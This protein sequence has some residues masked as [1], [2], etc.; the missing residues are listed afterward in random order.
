MTTLLTSA[1]ISDVV[2]IDNTDIEFVFNGRLYQLEINEL[3]YNDLS[4]FVKRNIGETHY[5]F[6]T[7]QFSE[8]TAKDI[9][10][11]LF[12]YA[13]DVTEY[14][15][16]GQQLLRKQARRN[17]LSW[18]VT[19]ANKM[20]SAL[21]SMSLALHTAWT[22]A[23]ILLSGFVQ[24]VKVGDVDSSEEIPV[25]SR[26]VASLESQG[27]VPKGESKPTGTLKFIDLDKKDSGL[28]LSACIISMH[29]WQ[30]VG[31]SSF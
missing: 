24:F 13:K 2:I 4:Y 29:V 27:F 20:R 17:L 19:T 31:W 10:I 12:S 15:D 5:E 6:V 16:K 23:K 25:F 7:C 14:T 18:I 1:Q 9:I 30:V 28:P 21:K 8:E 22:R 11:E 3:A 26:R